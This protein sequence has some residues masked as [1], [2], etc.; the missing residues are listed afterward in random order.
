MATVRKPQDGV[1]ETV[2]F[3]GGSETLVLDLMAMSWKQ[4]S[5]CK[6]K[7]DHSCSSTEC[8]LGGL[9][10]KL[11]QDCLYWTVRKVHDIVTMIER[12]NAWH[13]SLLYLCQG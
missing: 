2:S 11:A 5:L 1:K 12:Y 4:K 8:E 7:G 13:F 9:D 3:C 6:G 10:G